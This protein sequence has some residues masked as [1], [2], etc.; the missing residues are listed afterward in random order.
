MSSTTSRVE[1]FVA[2]VA[3]LGPVFEERAHVYD[4]EASF[5]HENWRVLPRSDS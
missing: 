3:E 2:A 5:P 1:E 4:R